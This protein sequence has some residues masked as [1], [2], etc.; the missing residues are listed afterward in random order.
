MLRRPIT[1][2]RPKTSLSREKFRSMHMLAWSS[3]LLAVGILISTIFLVPRGI[4]SVLSGVSEAKATTAEIIEGTVLFQPPATA[5]WQSMPDLKDLS[6]GSRVRTDDRSRAFLRTRDGSTVLLYNDT[7]L[8]LQRMQFGRFN[9]TLQDTVIRLFRGR[10]Q[11]GVAAHPSSPSRQITVLTRNG[12]FDLSEGSYRIE[13]DP[14]GSSHVSVRDG[15]ASIWSGNQSINLPAGLRAQIGPKG[16]IA[17][18]LPLERDLITDPLH[19]APL[20]DSPW[21]TFVVTEAGPSGT[22]NSSTTG[23]WF[24]R[25]T[26][27][28][29][30]DRHGESGIVQEIE[31][32]IRDYVNLTIR[33]DVRIDAQTLS[34]GGTAGTEYPLMIRITYVDTD[35]QEQIWATGFYHQN[36]DGL[37]IKLGREI[38]ATEW[39]TY[40]NSSLLQE[41]RPSPVHLRRIEILGSGWEYASGVRRM[42]LT[43]H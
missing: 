39:I 2:V 9:N 20:N 12:R 5:N 1:S 11:V 31:K 7:E 25:T 28:G 19:E 10:L 29:K 22:V 42:E 23:V 15:T 21:N 43:G 35:G 13:M 8:G 32:D 3:L 17:A 27:E 34:G 37:S 16:K 40:E 36:N 26:P 6:E 4:S 18:P 33:A 14:D 41:I 30:T 24:Q 38:P